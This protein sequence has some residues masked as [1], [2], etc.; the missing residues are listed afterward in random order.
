MGDGL[1][2]RRKMI[3]PKQT[4]KTIIPSLSIDMDSTSGAQAVSKQ[5]Q[6]LET[7]Q[8]IILEQQAAVQ[9]MMQMMQ[10]M[11]DQNSNN[12]N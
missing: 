9:S 12:S 6:L 3:Q 7:Q 10:M 4:K 1:I 8:A 2:F 5:H 11:Q